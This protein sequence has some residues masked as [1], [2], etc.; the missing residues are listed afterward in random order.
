ML[1]VVGQD[2]TMTF[3]ATAMDLLAAR[4]S[5]VAS[6]IANADTPGYRAVDLEFQRELEVAFERQRRVENGDFT[7]AKLRYHQVLKPRIVAVESQSHRLDGNNVD[8]D[9]EMMKLARINGMFEQA[10]TMLAFKLRFLK[11]AIRA[12]G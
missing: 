2:E 3:L 9:R 5:L 8:I 12:E 11:M 1:D 6:N 10:S 7:G 4:Q